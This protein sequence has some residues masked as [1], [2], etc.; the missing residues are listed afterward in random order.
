MR[1]TEG[2]LPENIVAR[3]RY[4][5]PDSPIRVTMARL[6]DRETNETLATGIARCSEQD[7]FSR[8]IGRSMAVGRAMKVLRS[9]GRLG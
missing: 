7:N 6:V 9:E 3:V 2:N 4:T 5:G 8:K 1:L